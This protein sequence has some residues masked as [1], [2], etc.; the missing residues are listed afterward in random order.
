M[1]FRSTNHINSTKNEDSGDVI[2]N[3]TATKEHSSRTLPGHMISGP[4]E[5]HLSPSD[6]TSSCDIIDESLIEQRILHKSRTLSEEDFRVDS[7]IACQRLEED[8]L[9]AKKLKEME[10]GLCVDL[11]LGSARSELTNGSNLGDSYRVTQERP[12]P[13]ESSLPTLMTSFS[14]ESSLYGDET[15]I[16]ENPSQIYPVSAVKSVATEPLIKSV[17]TEPLIKS[18]D[19]P[20]E[21]KERPSSKWNFDQDQKATFWMVALTAVRWMTVAAVFAIVLWIVNFLVENNVNFGLPF[22][23]QFMEDSQKEAI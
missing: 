8:R 15:E 20:T 3:L 12:H 23:F 18:V 22:E 4:S 2:V 10:G 21:E 6:E 17:A 13:K 9:K 19:E 16:E 11:H 7:A 14:T 1:T 5:S